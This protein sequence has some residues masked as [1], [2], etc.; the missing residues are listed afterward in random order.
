LTVRTRGLQVLVLGAVLTVA[1]CGGAQDDAGPEIAS[2]AGDAAVVGAAEPSA[3]LAPGAAM[4]VGDSIAVREDS[5]Y[6]LRLLRQRLA[7]MA[8][9]ADCMESAKGLGQPQ[10]RTIEAACARSR[11]N[12]PP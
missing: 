2:P 12:S 11:G 9:Y 6:E 5:L 7:S 4:T 1:A 10:R 3:A 8:T